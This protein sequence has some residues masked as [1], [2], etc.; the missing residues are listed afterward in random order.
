MRIKKAF[1]FLLLSF[2][3]LNLVGCE[4]F[5]RKFTRKNKKS[6]QPI[7]MVL[8]PEEYK[9]PD[10]SKEELY[11]QY[12]IYWKAWQDELINALTQKS[13]LKKKVDCAQEALKNLVN[14]KMQ[15]LLEAQKNFDPTLA[16]FSE[17]LTDLNNDV[18]GNR[19]NSNRQEAT[20]IKANIMRDFAYAKVRN[21]LK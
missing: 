20:Q 14:M 18:Y 5:A 8:A 12:F 19:D 11:R 13:S 21:Y 3:L 1:C 2:L 10:M 4:S 9:G 7:Q 17:L 15:L 16:R 6:N